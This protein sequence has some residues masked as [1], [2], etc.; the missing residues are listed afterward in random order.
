MRK[1]ADVSEEP[2]QTIE[3]KLDEIILY[4]HRME[5]RD[6]ARMIGSYIHGMVWL[7]SILFL[8]WSTWYFVA[9]G[10]QLIE[11]MTQKMIQQ[12]MG[13]PANGA[14]DSQSSGGYMQMLEDYMKGQ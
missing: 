13:M 9:Y 12:S 4:L 5:R 11:E 7:I 8:F 14:S 6:R 10:P 2:K 3:D 1:T